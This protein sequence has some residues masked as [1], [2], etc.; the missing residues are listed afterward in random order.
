MLPVKTTTVEERAD[1]FEISQNCG[2]TF[3]LGLV[4]QEVFLTQWMKIDFL[5]L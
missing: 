3:D 5:L 4:V 2:R 1:K